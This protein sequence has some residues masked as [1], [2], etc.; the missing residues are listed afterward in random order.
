[1]VATQD[2]SAPTPT[3]GTRSTRPPHFFSVITFT[4]AASGTPAAIAIPVNAAAEVP[5]VPGP[6]AATTGATRGMPSWSCTIQTMPPEAVAIAAQVVRLRGSDRTM[7]ASSADSSGASARTTRV[8]ATVVRV[9]A[10]MKQVNMTAQQA[11]E[12]HN[13]PPPRKNGRHHPLGSRAQ[14]ASPTNTRQ[15]AERQNVISTLA[16]AC[17]WRVITPA[18][19]QHRAQK[20]RVHA[21][22]VR[23]LPAGAGGDRDESTAKQYIGGGQR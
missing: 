4:D 20:T 11:P 10:I 6:V 14:S 8:L 1:M 17:R 13:T 21:A 22:R 18:V 7:R 2:S 23:S 5:A 9:S 19:D 3:A 16:A 15:K 12:S